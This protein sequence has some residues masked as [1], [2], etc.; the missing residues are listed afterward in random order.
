LILLRPWFPW[1]VALVV[2]LVAGMESGA[3]GEDH[4][5][6]T[7]RGLT[8]ESAF[9]V[10]VDVSDRLSANAKV[11]FGC[12]GFELDMMYFDWHPHEDLTVRVGRFSP[13]FGAFNLRHDPANH[14]LS[15]KPLPYDMGRMLRKGQWN[16]G[17]LPSPFPATGVE[18]GGTHWFGELAQIDYAAY[19]VSGFKNDTDP[20]PYDLNFQE[21]HLLYY[22]STTPRPA[23]GSR[24]ALTLK[25]A[26]AADVTMGVSGMGG[27]YD[28]NDRL[29]YLIGG[30]D[31]TVRVQR[32]SLRF[33]YVGRLQHFDT[34]DPALFKYALAGDRGDFFIKHGAYGEL[35]QPVTDR[36]DAIARLDWMGH[37]GNVSNTQVG[38]GSDE[39]YENPMQ[40][41][42][43]VVRET[44]GIVWTV[45]RNLRLKLSGELWEF[46]EADAD[47]RDV[48]AG[49]HVGAVG[50]F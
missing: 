37:E 39:I 17:V 22:V 45:E 38:N 36:V 21:S 33:E 24:F 28:V 48:V 29:G 11:C 20:H 2:L 44:L 5:Y 27:T 14:G 7:F 40:R 16:N 25:P 8:F 18:I 34:S 15:D 4:N 3:Y 9:K 10:A 35:E 13:S 12:H 30:L 50:T 41:H 43:Q 19:V 42:S 46:T 49:V 26:A 32:T 47:G 1:L 31:V 23:F 6:T